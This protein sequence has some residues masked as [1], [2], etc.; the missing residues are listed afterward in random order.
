M[1]A[2]SKACRLGTP[3][4]PGPPSVARDCF[5][6]ATAGPSADPIA[7]APHTDAGTC[8]RTAPIAPGP[9]RH[10]VMHGHNARIPPSTGGVVPV[11]TA[12]VSAARWISAS[13]QAI[14][15]P[16]AIPERCVLSHLMPSRATFGPD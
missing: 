2:L 9:A 10:A 4:M 6:L 14:M 11:T 12:H 16:G 7:V 13:P 1:L 15:S 5:A 3:G 8:A